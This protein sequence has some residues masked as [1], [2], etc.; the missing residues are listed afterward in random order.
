MKKIKVAVVGAAGKMGAEILLRLK[1][2]KDYIAFM[3]ITKSGS[4]D[5]FQQTKT[6]ASAKLKMVDL[7]IDFSAPETALQAAQLA[8]QAGTPFLSGTTGLSDPQM[9]ELFSYGKKI[10]VFW[11]P[12][13]SVGVAIFKKALRVFDGADQF[14]YQV[15]EFHHN[16]KKDKPSGT[17]KMIQQELERI[18]EKKLPPPIAVRGGG[19]FGVHKVYAMSSDEVICFEH[20]AL[21]RRVFA[22]GAMEV[23]KWLVK[24]PK[25]VYNMESYI[26]D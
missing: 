15:E 12:N 24:Q 25:G 9:K 8:A 10:P 5:G 6:I 18:V 22:S 2:D 23:G 20:Q 19:I 3:A 11:S 26:N 14:D 13:M 4:L 7:V 16:Q 21:G 17:A 1:S